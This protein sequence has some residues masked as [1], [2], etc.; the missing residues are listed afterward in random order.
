MFHSGEQQKEGSGKGVVNVSDTIVHKALL[1]W[2][3]AISI[4]PATAV[5]A[6]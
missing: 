3:M 5:Q 6:H 2:G 1:E 4:A